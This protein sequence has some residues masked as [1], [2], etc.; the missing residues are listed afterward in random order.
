MIMLSLQCCTLTHVQGHLIQSIGLANFVNGSWRNV[1]VWRYNTKQLTMLQPAVWPK[2]GN[3]TP[4]DYLVCDPGGY[5]S[6]HDGREFCRKCPVGLSSVIEGPKLQEVESCACIESLPSH[7]ASSSKNGT[8]LVS[9]WQNGTEIALPV[10]YGTMAC[11]EHDKMAHPACIE[12]TG[13]EKPDA[14]GWCMQP[15]C[16]VRNSCK[17]CD[18]QESGFSTDKA[19][20][21]WCMYVLCC[22]TVCT[23]IC[24]VCHTLNLQTSDHAHAHE[25]GRSRVTLHPRIWAFGFPTAIAMPRL[26]TLAREQR[27]QC[28]DALAAHVRQGP[29]LTW[30]GQYGASIAATSAT[31]INISPRR[32]PV[33]NVR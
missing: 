27:C 24:G 1:G 30:K 33:S 10:S 31:S 8:R 12:F 32:Q 21:L 4:R 11:Q 25:I 15:W 22:R 6:I 7:L 9:L 13:R 2:T 17:R 14:P 16:Y 26:P 28:N 18:L 19:C 29:T 3:E 20:V 23:D 5:R